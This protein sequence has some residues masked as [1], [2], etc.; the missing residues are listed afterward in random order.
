MRVFVTG[1][2]GWIGSAIVQELIAAGHQ[3][4]GL[5]R[6]DERAATL[7]ATGAAVHRGDLTEET[8]SLVAGAMACDGVI[9]TAFIHDWSQY[10][11]SVETDRA[12][13]EAMARALEGS[14]KPLVIAS[15]T[16]MIAALG[17]LG[18]E[19]DAAPNPDGPRVA[20]EK[21]VLAAPGVRGAVVRLPPTVHGAGDQ[22]FTSWLVTAA[23]SRTARRSMSATAPI[24]GRRC[25]G[26]TRRGCSCAV[27]RRPR[28]A[29]ACTPSPTRACP[30]AR[31]R[32]PSAMGSAFRSAA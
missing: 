9:H 5:A 20:S 12:A 32:K 21:I 16:M 10:M 22:G 19:T 29:R 3:V 30:C 7:A 31:S 25:T 24:A 18:L 27:W 11:A 26:W 4:L 6:S 2:T 13:V 1:A 23:R 14:G 17:R 28:R 8:G 15:G